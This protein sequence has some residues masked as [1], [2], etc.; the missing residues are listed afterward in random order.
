MKQGKLQVKH[1]ASTRTV[2]ISRVMRTVDA[3]TRHEV[4]NKRLLLLENDNFVEESTDWQDEA[5]GDEAKD[6]AAAMAPKVTKKARLQTAGLS[7]WA[8]RRPKPLE[9]IIHEQG[10]NVQEED[11]FA[12]DRAA[13]VV[14]CGKYPNIVSVN[15]GPSATPARK[16]C[17]VCGL[18][19]IYSC[20]RCG[21]KS[22]G[23]K[24]STVHKEEQCLN[25]SI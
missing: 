8:L 17:G 3:E 6:G 5:Y 20:K 15:A 19:G 1:R 14:R 23:I 7:K 12:S 25:G 11:H 18:S 24:C 21:S 2:V 13:V 4:R 16:L 9:R 10:Y 22:C